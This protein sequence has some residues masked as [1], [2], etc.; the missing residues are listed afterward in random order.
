MQDLKV[1]TAEKMFLASIPKDRI[2]YSIG[3]KDKSF[4]SNIP[5]AKSQRLETSSN[6]VTSTSLL[7][8]EFNEMS[9][10]LTTITNSLKSIKSQAV[11]HIAFDS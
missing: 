4:L 10:S 9:S 2:Q 3:T 7:Q 5:L 8:S 6:T 1:E 11:R